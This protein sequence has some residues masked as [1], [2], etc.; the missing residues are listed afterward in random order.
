MAYE[1]AHQIE[2]LESGGR[3]FQQTMGW[4]DGRGVTYVQRKEEYAE[5]YLVLPEPDLPP[6][7]IGREWLKE[8][9]RGCRNFRRLVG[10]VS[11][12]NTA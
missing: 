12:R 2:V 7:E 6:L 4:D 9:R 10:P 3:V 1:I 11:S 8:L 5:D